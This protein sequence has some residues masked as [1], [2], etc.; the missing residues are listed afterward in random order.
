MAAGRSEQTKHNVVEA[1]IGMATIG[2]TWNFFTKA[3]GD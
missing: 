1:V 2:H 3:C